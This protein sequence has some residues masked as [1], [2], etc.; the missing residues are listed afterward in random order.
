MYLYCTQHTEWLWSIVSHIQQVSGGCKESNE[1]SSRRERSSLMARGVRGI[2]PPEG[3]I[4]SP[5]AGAVHR[6]RSSN[7]TREGKVE[8]DDAFPDNLFSHSRLRMLCRVQY[9]DLRFSGAFRRLLETRS[10][11]TAALRPWKFPR[12]VPT[13]G[14]SNS[15]RPSS[16]PLPCRG[17]HRPLSAPL[18]FCL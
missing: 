16:P 6:L 10:R 9:Q 11:P 8:I 2:H 5:A 7:E 14:A 18:W 1:H 17:M 15:R 12:P 13:P 4:Q 3:H